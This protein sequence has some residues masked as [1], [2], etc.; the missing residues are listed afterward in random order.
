MEL[1]FLYFLFWLLDCFL[2][3]SFWLLDIIVFSCTLFHCIYRYILSFFL[4]SA[5]SLLILSPS[6]AFCCLWH[7]YSAAVFVLMDIISVFS[8]FFLLHEMKPDADCTTQTGFSK[9]C[10]MGRT[11]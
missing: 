1:C 2:C 7:C 3:F 11:N 8:S 10:L 9:S 6:L 4:F 5:A